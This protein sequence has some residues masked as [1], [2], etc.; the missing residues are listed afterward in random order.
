MK[1]LVLTCSTGGGHNVTANAICEHFTA[2][3]HECVVI[4]CLRFLPSLTAKILSEGHIFLYRNAPKLFGIGYR[5]E[6][7]HDTKLIRTQFMACAKEFTKHAQELGGDATISSH[8]FA[9]LITTA[10]KR[11]CGLDIPNFFVATDYTCCPGVSDTEQDLYFIPHA[12]LLSTFSQCGIPKDRLVPSGIPVRPAF[13]KKHTQEQAR[14]LLYLPQTGKVLLL[15]CGSMG[16]GPMQELSVLLDRSMAPEDHLIVICGTNGRLLRSLQKKNLSGRVRLLGFTDQIDLY[17][18]AADLILTKPGGISTT[19]ALTKRLP[20]VYVD[21][22]P[23]CETRNLEFIV[24][25]G[26]AFTAETPAQL[27]ALCADLLGNEQR[28]NTWRTKLEEAFPDC[29]IDTIYQHVVQHMQKEAAV[30]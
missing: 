19:E 4:D 2:H 5:Y 23:G 13:Y 27:A 21:A 17:M 20:L 22:V 16:A 28:L 30:Q 3:G 14:D 24:S 29:A 15:S 1:L 18:D 12:E 6:E 25:R 7:N 10:A 8:P 11:R 9:A 26:Y